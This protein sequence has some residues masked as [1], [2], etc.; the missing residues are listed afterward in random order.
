[1]KDIKSSII[2]KNGTQYFDWTAS[3]LAHKGVE[4]RMLEVLQTYSNTHS[5]CGANAKATSELYEFAR[6]ELKRL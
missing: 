3:G 6:R 5:E 2:L 1:M 4:E